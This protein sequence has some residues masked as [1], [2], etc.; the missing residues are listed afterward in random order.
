MRLLTGLAVVL[1]IVHL[2]SAVSVNILRAKVAAARAEGLFWTMKCSAAFPLR[3]VFRSRL[4]YS[5]LCLLRL[6]ML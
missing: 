6:H 3:F 5:S 4:Y 2:S 1:L